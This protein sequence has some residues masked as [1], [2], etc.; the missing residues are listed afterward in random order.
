MTKTI[1]RKYVRKLLEA[2]V[3]GQAAAGQ[4]LA[5]F[6]TNKSNNVEYILYDPKAFFEKAQGLPAD[7]LSGIDPSDVVY[8]YLNAKPH[9]GDCWNAAEI[10]FSAA[11]KGYGP[12][13]YELAMSDF[14]KIMSDHGAGSS[15]SARSVWQKYA[16][17]SDVKK[18]PFDDQKNP[19]TPPKDDDCK[20]IPDFDGSVAYLNSAYAGSGDVSGKEAMMN[21]HQSFV[22]Q[23]EGANVKKAD[24]ELALR[25]MGDEYFGKRYQENL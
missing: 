20:M 24:V 12:L 7:E 3:V 15:Q 6:R 1:L 11:R 25:L 23:M 21:A 5:L 8:G 10:K 4:G 14:G 2:A 18:L 9:Q 13:L 19:K 16:Q 17:R 22:K